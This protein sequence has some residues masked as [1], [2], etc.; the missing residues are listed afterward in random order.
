L[1]LRVVLPV[2]A[3]FVAIGVL[4]VRLAVA[5]QRQ[6]AVTGAGGMIGQTGQALTAIGPAATGRIATRGEIWQA[7][8]GES[9]PEGTP[10]RVTAVDGLTLTVR[11][12]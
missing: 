8:S 1:S 3:G 12:E 7:V 9:I 5:A 6:P 10:V 11:K 4:L 2:V